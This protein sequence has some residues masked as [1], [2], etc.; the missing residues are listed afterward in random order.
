MRIIFATNKPFRRWFGRL[1]FRVDSKSMLQYRHKAGVLS[2][3]KDHDDRVPIGVPTGDMAFVEGRRM[4]RVEV[5][6][7]MGTTPA[8]LLAKQEMDDG[9]RRGNSPGYIIYAMDMLEEG[10][11]TK[12]IEPLY[13]ATL[14]E[15][16]EI[17]STTM[18]AMPDAKIIGKADLL[19]DL[20]E[21][22][23]AMASMVSEPKAYIGRAEEEA[24]VNDAKARF[25]A[26]KQS[27]VDSASD[28]TPHDD[29]APADQLEDTQPRT[30]EPAAPDSQTPPVPA[31]PAKSDKGDTS[32]AMDE[33]ERKKLEAEHARLQVLADRAALV[34]AI[35]ELGELTNHRDL[36]AVAIQNKTD[37]ETFKTQIREADKAKLESVQVQ[38]APMVEKA[39]EGAGRLYD[40]HGAIMYAS[41]YGDQGPTRQKDLASEIV[42]GEQYKATAGIPGGLES[43]AGPGHLIIPHGAMSGQATLIASTNVSGE[44]AIEVDESRYM[45]WLLEPSYVMAMTDVVPNVTS[46]F[47]IPRGAGAGPQV[48]WV[49]ENLATLQ[50]TSAL[51]DTV[52]PVPKVL[53]GTMPYTD[54]SNIRTGGF[55]QRR[56]SAG[57]GQALAAGIDK[58][59]L[60]GAGCKPP[61]RD[62][63]RV[64]RCTG[65]Q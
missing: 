8:A 43:I 46:D 53:L 49:A 34:D 28:A 59:I 51:F 21:E 41:G 6:I 4:N 50:D 11:Y 30:P 12:G 20:D 25:E 55:V 56:V 37:L 7:A 58:S 26:A 3:L 64:R 13:E 29:D 44:I 23:Y 42:L 15:P 57:F 65:H 17:S 39:K 2:Y 54:L 24:L 14:W 38:P 61:D 40:L 32:S 33:E 1:Q 36:A 9:G 45:D 16:A 48:T 27:G 10:D 22:E 35:N 31:D 47:R 18:P 52:A 62:S 5:D 63:G 60:V 19:D